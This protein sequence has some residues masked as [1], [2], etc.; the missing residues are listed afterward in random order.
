[1]TLLLVSLVGL[2]ATAVAALVAGR[3]GR[4][5]AWIGVGGAWVFS[6]TALDAALRALLSGGTEARTAEWSVPGGR[7]A[8]ELDPLSAWFLLPIFLLAP[9]VALAAARWLE[10]RRARG[11]GPW[12]LLHLLVVSMAL[13]VV[14]R[15]SVLF[16]V[17]WE[18]M[19]LAGYGLMAIDAGDEPAA[20]RAGGAFAWLV[21]SHLGTAFLAA[22]LL[23][24]HGR[25]LAGAGAL[26]GDHALRWLLLALVGFGTKA[27]LAPFHSWAGDAYGSAPGHVGALLAGATSKLGIYGLLRLWIA[28]GDARR[29]PESAVWLL[30]A[31]GLASSLFGALA[32]V[33]E[34]D[35]RRVLAA[36]S[37]ESSGLVV[38]GI[39]VALLGRSVEAN[40]IAVLGL[41]AAL[42]HVLHDAVFKALL[43]TGAGAVAS[44]AGSDALDRLGGLLKLLPR[45]GLFMLVG[46]ASLVALPPFSGFTSELLLVAGAFEGAASLAPRVAA[47]LFLVIGT[48]AFVAGLSLAAMARALG[49]VFLGVPRDRAAAGATE[50]SRLA[51]AP[52]GFLAALCLL[53]GLGAPILVQLARPVVAQLLGDPSL[54]EWCWRERAVTVVVSGVIGASL[55]G[56]LIYVVAQVRRLLRL[57][58]PASEAVTWDGGYHR[59]REPLFKGFAPL[60]SWPRILQHGRIHLYVLAIAA[61]L[62]VLLI[63]ES[64]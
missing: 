5:S 32:S 9:L 1:M 12:F 51:L 47:P 28:L 56:A 7:L 17:A 46:A 61:T 62:L 6:V 58:R 24:S 19:V 63:L 3:L 49:A 34:R 30:L 35:L 55:L 26:E 44:A 41:A 23:L 40:A 39:A 38:V 21:A 4:A 57:G 45:T 14:A 31:V 53:G 22:L 16:L 60:N 33:A 64:A 11:G 29:I 37:T 42:L 8:V 54:W 59:P 20:P 43:F 25:L 52:L 48:T 50:P 36:S 2:A 13:V 10:S 18:T 27:A 15:D